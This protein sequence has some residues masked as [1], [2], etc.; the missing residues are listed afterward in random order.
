MDDGDLVRSGGQKDLLVSVNDQTFSD[1]IEMHDGPAF[2][3]FQSATCQHCRTITPYIREY[4][5]EFSDRVLFATIEVGQNPRVVERFGIRSTPTFKFFCKGKPIQELVGAVY[6]AIIK[7][8]IEEFLH[9]GNE[10]AA[11]STE[12]DYE[13]S[14]Y[15]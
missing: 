10:C 2:V 3:I 4:A 14:G 5:G 13:I 1:M 11:N 15:A 12:I 7:R 9:Y 6:P 8:Q